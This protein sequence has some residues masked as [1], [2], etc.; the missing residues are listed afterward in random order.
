MKLNFEDK[1]PE[2]RKEVERQEDKLK[3]LI[4]VMD[5]RLKDG[6]VE[7]LFFDSSLDDDEVALRLFHSLDDNKNGLVDKLELKKLQQNSDTEM[8]L[9]R[10]LQPEAD[11]L[12]FMAFKAVLR[13]VPRVP[14]QRTAWIRG[15]L[16]EADLA[17]HLRPGTLDDGLAGVK[18]TSSQEVDLLLY[19]FFADTR[20]KFFAEWVKVR[21]PGGFKSAV[22]ANSKF[23]GFDGTFASL[24]DFHAGQNLGYPN[25]D[26]RKGIRLEHTAH[27]SRNRLFVSSNYRLATSL[28][29]EYAWAMLDS[30]PSAL[31]EAKKLVAQLRKAR[32]EIGEGEESVADADELEPLFPGEVGDNFVESL[33]MVSLRAESDIKAVQLEATA[34]KA[35]GEVVASILLTEEERARGVQTLSVAACASWLSR[36]TSVLNLRSGMSPVAASDPLRGS[37]VLG[38]ILPM[39]K[40]RA[41][42]V[43][44]VL[45]K[46][47]KEALVGGVF[48]DMS[49]KASKTWKFCNHVSS[50]A[51]LRSLSDMDLEDL[52]QLCPN[53]GAKSLSRKQII[54]SALT[55][56][57]SDEL[58]LDFRRAL[59]NASETQLACLFKGWELYEVSDSSRAEQIESAVKALDS[60]ERWRQVEEWVELYRGR[61]QGRTRLG[62]KKLM[63][64]EKEI[65][66]K[67]K[68]KLEI[69]AMHLYTGPEFIPMNSICR[70]HP[71]N[72]MDLLKGDGPRLESNR[73][74]TT[75]FCVSS[76][77]KKLGRSTEVPEN[78]TVYRGLGHMRLP[79]EF[80]TAS[81]APPW[82][83]GV[84]RAFMSTTA[85]K[86]VALYYANGKGTVVEI[87][88]GRVQIGGDVS[89][90]SMVG[91]YRM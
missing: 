63:E 1:A 67:N 80:W 15:M 82:R 74:C 50:E 48:I 3:N 83:G 61:I 57:V 37:F 78:R 62:I 89:F 21:Q 47:L 86:D 76:G 11:L 91:S 75:L 69:L 79:S 32:A 2:L 51:K 73:L 43:L 5:A 56:F 16:L 19:A 45:Q 6:N 65:I 41:S 10:A 30:D 24:E 25:P 22:E 68:L 85:D 77:L 88:V 4:C 54:T 59:E 84:E 26:L 70:N 46:S 66:L 14:G 18:Q 33:V 17:R 12:D 35:I 29:I 34:L 44:G 87:S 49:L 40:T 90:L 39:C 8:V 81:G 28:S 31:A 42:K 36:S 55:S 9:L 58:Q 60:V 27:P 38:L 64:R 72:I 71:Q 20:R 13:K 52:R 23:D 53:Q 7:N